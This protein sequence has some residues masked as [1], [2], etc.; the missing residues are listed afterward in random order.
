MPPQN[1]LL[2]IDDSKFTC[3]LLADIFNGLNC[4]TFAAHRMS[5]ALGLLQSQHF[6]RYI[7]KG[8]SLESE[9]PG[10]GNGQ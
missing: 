4:E 2:C 1:R 8:T 9:V 3:S 10:R 7:L 6:D 5:D